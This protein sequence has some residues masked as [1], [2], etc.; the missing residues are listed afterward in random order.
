MSIHL[1]F[2]E[3]TLTGK[4]SGLCKCGKRRTRSKTFMQT[5][6]PFNTNPDGSLKTRE[7]IYPQLREKIAA[8]KLEPITC[9]DCEQE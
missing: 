6:N 3:V 1:R 8:W 9:K 7:D 5:L 4:K 2:K